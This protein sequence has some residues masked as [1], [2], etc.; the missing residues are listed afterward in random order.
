MTVYD[1][2]IQIFCY[3]E[4]VEIELSLMYKIDHPK[5]NQVPQFCL[6]PETIITCTLH[7]KKIIFNCYKNK[8]ILEITY[9]DRLRHK[10]SLETK[11]NQRIF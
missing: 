2:I 6:P 7:H 11:P 8:H 4:K 10:R 3:I 1:N 9:C 5:C